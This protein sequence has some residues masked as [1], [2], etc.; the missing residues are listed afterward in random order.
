MVP[1]RQ[2]HGIVQTGRRWLLTEE[3][4]IQIPG[5]YM[6]DSWH[7]RKFPLFTPANHRSTIAPC[8]SITAV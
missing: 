6:R 7:W 8:S 2:D 5:D 1:P 3:R 4:Q